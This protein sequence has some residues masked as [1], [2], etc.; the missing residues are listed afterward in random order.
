MLLLHSGE[1]FNPDFYYHSGLEVDNSFLL[2]HGARRIIFVP[3][4]NE[5]LARSRFSGRVVAYEDAFASLSGYIKGKKVL[6][7]GRSLS[8]RSA[9][10]LGKLCRLKDCSEELLRMRAV[11]RKDEVSLICRA[12]RHTKDLFASLDFKKAKTELDVKKQLLLSTLELGLEPAFDPIVATDRNSA[13][14]HYNPGNKKLGSLVLV[15]YGVRYRHYCADVTRCFILDGDGEKKKHYERLQGVFH[16]LLDALPDMKTGNE[17]AGLADRLLEKE[18]FPKLFHSIGH[19]VGLAVHEYPRL[20]LRYKD[21][22]SGSV[23]AIEPAFYLDRYGMRYEDVVYFD[24]K[25]ARIL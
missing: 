2:L 15:D 19:G 11:K 22:I 16:S 8:A 13:Y 14:P 7:D 25:R 3:K 9:E 12:V 5:S 10:K 20:S 4:M 6:F 23:C 18:N 17:V 21:C 24:G 1:G